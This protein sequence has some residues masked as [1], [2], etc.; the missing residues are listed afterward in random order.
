M[1]KAARRTWVLG[2][3]G[4]RGAAQV[5][6]LQALFEAGV[7]APGGV[8]G[9]SVGA[10]NGGSVAAYP[11]LAGA[12][13]LR[14]GWLSRPAPAALPAPPPCRLRS[15]AARGPPPRMPPPNG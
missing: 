5:G 12:M 2:G 1:F 10:P 13:M 6:V 3:G 11:P 9:T 4:A 15:G 7:E 8:V 14:E